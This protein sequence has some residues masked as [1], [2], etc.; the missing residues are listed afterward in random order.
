MLSKIKKFIN[1]FGKFR[2]DA[3]LRRRIKDYEKDIILGLIVFLL[4]L[5]SF[6]AGYLLAKN[7]Q[8]QPLRFEETKQETFLCKVFSAMKLAVNISQ[9]FLGNM[10]IDLGS[11]NTSVSQEFLNCS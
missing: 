4:S 2:I 10:S 5:L 8:K 11:K 9:S 7:Q 6:A 1:P 3:E